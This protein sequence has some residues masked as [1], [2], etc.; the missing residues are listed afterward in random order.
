YTTLFRSQGNALLVNGINSVYQVVLAST[1]PSDLTDLRL[2]GNVL[3]NV[4]PPTDMI[5]QTTQFVGPPPTP[6]VP[7]SNGTNN[8]F[9][10]IGPN[11]TFGATPFP[12]MTF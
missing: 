1:N 10:V 11:A 9:F 5:Y 7:A 3:G 8:P 2:P 12:T 6:P 4:V